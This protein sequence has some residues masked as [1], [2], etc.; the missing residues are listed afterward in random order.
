MKS[1][2][3]GTLTF[4]GVVMIIF[5][6]VY[7]LLGTLSL[8]GT[9]TGVLPGHEKQEIIIVILSYIIAIL[10]IIGGITSVRGKFATA[11]TVSLIFAVIGLV[12]LIYNQ[13]TQDTFNNFDCIT[14][15]LGA[16]ICYLATTAKKEDDQIKAIQAKKKKQ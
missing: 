7:A 16:G 11:R 6:L 8:M 13:V 9:I 1:E 15:V 14:M 2:G 12:S 10:A 5:G 3:H 4:L